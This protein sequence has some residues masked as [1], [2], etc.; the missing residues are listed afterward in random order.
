MAE[1]IAQTRARLE[2]FIADN[3]A[4][5][6]IAPGSVLSELLIKLSAT[7][8]N[9]IHN[10]IDAISQTQYVSSALDSATDTYNDVINSIAS[11]YN[12]S[13]NEGRKVTGRIKVTVSSSKTYFLEKGFT[14]QQPN[15][16]FQYLTTTP[17][18]VVFRDA[19]VTLTDGQLRL[20]QEGSKFYFIVSV[21]AATVGQEAVGGDKNNTQ[22][23]NLTRFALGG[24][25][26]L[27]GFVQAEAY[28]NFSSGQDI[29]T[30]RELITRFKEGLAN[31]SVTS[32]K[33]LTSVLKINFPTLKNISVVGSNDP[34]LV[35]NKANLFG[36]STFGMADVYIRTSDS[37][38]TTTIAMT[39]T[40]VDSST[41]QI[42]IN[43]ST[44]PGFYRVV[45][46]TPTSPGSTGTYV[47][48][49]TSYGYQA[50][51]TTRNNF[52]NVPSDARLTKYQTC[53]LTFEATNIAASTTTTTFN[54][55][56]SYS[57][58]VQDIQDYLISDQNRVA[59]ADYLVKAV[60]PCEVSLQLNL[61]R[62]FPLD[63]VPVS[64]IKRDIFS[65]IN[66]LTFGEDLVISK[67]IDICHNYNIKRVD[68]PIEVSGTILIP[69][70]SKDQSILITGE[71]SLSIPTVLDKGISKNT[72]AFFVN[73]LKEDGQTDNIGIS[74]T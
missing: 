34:E 4:D 31:K 3:F 41:W 15:L 21:E 72:T 36:I 71:D 57:P 44:V 52:I 38:E 67:I 26:K 9:E 60:I 14:F 68:L 56:I 70:V 10:D 48:K 39:G 35:R 63:E 69:G 27:D 7:L 32:P 22:V 73:Y 6:D 55:L 47:I 66:N 43:K 20:V 61:F 54:V 58:L 28:G 49:T 50:D 19:S 33:S 2:A 64:S 5:A 29:E 23:T 74:V 40:R 18:E 12:V 11:N 24:T 65:Y 51:S 45:S 42:V 59:C 17:Y 25:S 37:I 62:K 46:V 30:D 53:T 16:K 8:H 1:S 13:R